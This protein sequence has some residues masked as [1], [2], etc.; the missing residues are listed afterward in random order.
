MTKTELHLLIFNCL[1]EGELKGWELD[2]CGDCWV[3]EGCLVDSN[4]SPAAIDAHM[5]RY[6]KTSVSDS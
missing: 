6:Y 2:A 5:Y 3:S 1:Q 4:D